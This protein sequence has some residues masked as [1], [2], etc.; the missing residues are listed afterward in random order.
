[1]KDP[2]WPED[3]GSYGPFT[4]HRPN[5]DRAWLWVY[6]AFV[7][8]TVAWGGY[9]VY[10]RNPK[11]TDL[12]TP[13][14]LNDPANCPVGSR[15]SLLEAAGEP[16]DDDFDYPKYIKEGAVWLLASLVGALVIGAFWVTLFKSHARRMISVAVGVQVAIP[17]AVGISLLMG[18]AAVPGL[19]MCAFAM[20]MAACFYSIRDRLDYTAS[21]LRVSAKGLNDNTPLVWF[22]ILSNVVLGVASIPGFAL[23]AVAYMNGH[24]VPVEGRVEQ[25]G[26]CVAPP[27]DDG[28]ASGLLGKHAHDD[29]SEPSGPQVPCCA[30]RPDDWVPAY[31]AL[32]GL[33]LLWTSWVF[34]QLRIFVVSGTVSQWYFAPAHI[35]GAS[36]ARV[37]RSLGHAL[38]PSAGS[39]CFGAAIMTVVDLVRQS[40]RNAR[41]RNRGDGL[42]Q[43][44][45]CLFLMA[46]QCL[47]ELIEYIT[48]Y[49]TVYAAISGDAFLQ[50][51]RDI[52]DLL[53]RNVLDAFT[54]WWVPGFVLQMTSLVAAA[55]WGV[56]VGL[57]AAVRWR[58]EDGGGA[59]AIILGVAAG[60]VALVVLS[61]LAGLLLNVVDAVFVCFAIDRDAQVVTQSD[62]HDVFLGLPVIQGAFVEQPGGDLMFGEQQQGAGPSGAQGSGYTTLRNEDRTKAPR[63]PV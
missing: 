9:G 15:R 43:I 46:A 44:L 6:L 32:A 14:Y 54:V 39:L 41:E 22:V 29:P 61:F 1:M 27:S 3:G 53:K 17:A 10:A 47:T 59:A 38:G 4:T 55:V 49:A 13:D 25:D 24:V 33:T 56:A 5:R 2:A 60:V 8:A 42:A 18:G 51:G 52:I 40:I 19:I 30:W 34:S 20:I 48:K 31:W 62:V 45:Y 28:P 11:F 26:I 36:S 16:S 37:K 12:A 21:M 58:G 57:L 50:A 23:M 7:A 35:T 63:S